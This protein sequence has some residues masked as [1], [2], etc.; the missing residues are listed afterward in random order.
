MAAFLGLGLGVQILLI[1]LGL[2]DI[3]EY[4]DRAFQ[5]V[6]LLADNVAL[7]WF[8]CGL[9]CVISSVFVIWNVRLQIIWLTILLYLS[10]LSQG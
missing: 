4:Q 8:S 9:C 2:F 7:I 1:V 6:S 3:P 10:L 5:G